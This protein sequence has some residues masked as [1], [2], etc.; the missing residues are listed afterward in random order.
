MSEQ[1]STVE[2]D[3]E[4]YPWSGGTWGEGTFDPD[5]YYP[6]TD[7]GQPTRSTFEL[8][9][10]VEIADPFDLDNLWFIDKEQVE[11]AGMSLQVLE[12]QIRDNPDAKLY[13]II[14]T[15]GT[16]AMVI[17]DGV[18]IAKLDTKTILGELPDSEKK[19]YKASSFQLPTLIDSA[20]MEIDY[21]AD[22]VIAM[23]YMWKHMPEHVRERFAG[24]GI[25]HGTDTLYAAGAAT[26][27]MLGPNL[28]FNVGYV[29]AQKSIGERPNDISGN[30]RG[31]L[32]SLSKLHDDGAALAFTYFG[33]DSGAA[34]NAT[35]TVKISD[36]EFKGFN[37]PMH[38]PI[39][40]FEQF[41]AKGGDREFIEKNAVKDKSIEDFFPIILGGYTEM[42]EIVLR[43]GVD[44]KYQ[45]AKVELAKMFGQ[46]ALNIISFG[47][48]TG[49]KKALR[50]VI[51]ANR[52]DS[53]YLEALRQVDD[54]IKQSKKHL[55][56]MREAARKIGMILFSSNPFPEGET[57]HVYESSSI[58]RDNTYTL[59]LLPES[60]PYFFKIATTLFP[61]DREAQIAFMRENDYVGEQP[62]DFLA[63]AFPV[64]KTEE[65][66]VAS[67]VRPFYKTK[68]GVTIPRVGAPYIEQLDGTKTPLASRAK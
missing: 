4:A 18:K 11:L 7:Y 34:F 16:I 25:T 46:R 10:G 48:F 52:D 50:A 60:A 62:K 15:G 17:D 38:T 56:Q 58:L 65:G 33:G 1:A 37:S 53:E 42:D 6:E 24:F 45:T 27:A 8:M 35:S 44:P 31:L 59:K 30:V 28:P 29:A 2:L 20:D 41:A 14:G 68:D 54:E 40:E 21:W 9:N 19:D 32:Y 51:G 67:R 23:S 64:Y 66:G 12:S 13:C 5:L 49:P 39:I 61:D 3:R 43:Q 63:N 22:T 47:G 36:T 57:D 55:T 26:S